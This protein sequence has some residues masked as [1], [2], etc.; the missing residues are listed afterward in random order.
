M[1]Q[2]PARLVHRNLI[3]VTRWGAEGSGATVE[4]ADGGVLLASPSK[5]QFLNAV[6]REDPGA[7]AGGLLERARDFFFERGRGFVVYTWP[8]DPELGRAALAAGMSPVLERYPEMV[9]RSRLDPVA[10]D[11]RAVDDVDAAAA[12]W[13][14]CDAA[15]PSIGFSEGLFSE[16]FSPGL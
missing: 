10:G 1:E 5:L 4:E 2:S 12:Y 3:D 15:Y 14:I 16:I 6:M 13:R 11:V 8:G 7:D 9:C